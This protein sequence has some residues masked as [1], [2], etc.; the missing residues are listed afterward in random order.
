MKLTCQR[1]L[2]DASDHPTQEH[3]V[4][5]LSFLPG[6]ILFCVPY[7]KELFF[8]VGEL[9]AKTDLDLMVY[10]TMTAYLQLIIQCFESFFLSFLFR[11]LN[12]MDLKV[13]IEYGT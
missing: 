13:L 10:F 5:L 9:V 6:E 12:T 8:Q 1:D 3:I 7:T 4:R 2:T 11:S